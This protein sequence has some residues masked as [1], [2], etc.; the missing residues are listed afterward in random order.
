VGNVDTKSGLNEDITITSADFY[1]KGIS[2]ENQNYVSRNINLETILILESSE[3]V[4]SIDSF[5]INNSDKIYFNVINKEGLLIT[6]EGGDSKYKLSFQ[7]AS[8]SAD[9]TYSFN[10]D[11]PIQT[12][13]SHYIVP[14]INGNE[15]SARIYIDDNGDGIFKESILITSV[16]DQFELDKGNSQI[17]LYPNPSSGIFNLKSG[18]LHDNDLEVSI[19]DITNRLVSHTKYNSRNSLNEQFDISAFPAGVYIVR[20]KGEKTN[21]AAKL[22][23]DLLLFYFEGL[24]S[25]L[26]G[27]NKS[28][29]VHLASPSSYCQGGILLF[30]YEKRALLLFCLDT[31]ETRFNGSSST[32]SKK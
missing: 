4:F 6:N 23:K 14:I 5:S 28:L 30:C 19:Y 31:A 18:M 16:E 13:V 21:I 17:W 8:P 25:A 22:I 20:I 10:Q 9:S 29:I 12:G 24:Q 27:C 11:I 3:I 7:I 26:P 1:G 32:K 2:I 15:V